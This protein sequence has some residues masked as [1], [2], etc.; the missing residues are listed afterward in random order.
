LITPRNAV[1]YLWN[2]RMLEQHCRRTGHTCYSFYALDSCKRSPLS[3]QQRLEIMHLKLDKTNN[4]PHKVDIAI[5]MN[6]MLLYNTAP[7]AGLANSSWGIVIDIVLDPREPLKK[8][9]ANTVQLSYLPT[10]IL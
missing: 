8:S 9:Y 7:H 2:A 10:A 1:Q 5:S 4:L 6:T 3:L